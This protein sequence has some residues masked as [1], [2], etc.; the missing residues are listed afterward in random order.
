M[1]HSKSQAYLASIGECLAHTIGESEA[2]F[3][4]PC[5]DQTCEKVALDPNWLAVM[6]NAGAHPFEEW[7]AA[8]TLSHCESQL[9]G[10]LIAEEQ[11]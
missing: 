4:P 3:L 6:A 9:I 7:S 8:R 10:E 11:I 1:W 5:R 2:D